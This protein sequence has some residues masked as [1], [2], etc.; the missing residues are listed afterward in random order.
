LINGEVLN[1]RDRSSTDEKTRSRVLFIAPL[2]DPVN[3]QSLACKVFLDELVQLHDVDVVDLKKEGFEQ[4]MNSWRRFVEV[5]RIIAA[6]WR[7][8]K[9]ADVVYFTISESRAGNMKDLLIYA[10]CRRRLDSMIVKLY[11]GAG[12][13][14]LLL[15][16]PTVRR[17]VNEFFLKR[18]GAVVV[19]GKTHVATFAGAV[20]PSRVDVVHNFAEEF[21]FADEAAIRSKFANAN[22]LKLLFLSN[23]LPGKGHEELLEGYRL[24]PSELRERVTV[25]FAGGFES[26]QDEQAFLQRLKETPGTRYH[27]VANRAAKQKL[28]QEAHVF[29]LPTYYPYEG[30][31]L[32]ILEAYAAGCVVITT[33]HSGIRDVFQGGRNGYEVRTRSPADVTAAITQALAEPARLLEMALASNLEARAKY[34]AAHHNTRL[35]EIVQRVASAAVG[36]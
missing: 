5:G 3:G 4:G 2:P 7:R 15:G 17:A 18:V 26:V 8:Q 24:L 23:L 21:L 35:V 9:Q 16:K 33:D 25:D 20:P 22:P 12:I 6:V 34:R 30:Q 19:E 10:A 28:F 1:A 27:G 13:R 36:A 31:P 11:G 32:S 14:R 29:C